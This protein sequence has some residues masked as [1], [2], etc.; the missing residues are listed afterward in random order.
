MS[1]VKCQVSGVTCHFFLD[2]VVGI[3]GGGSVF[4]GAYPVQSLH[5]THWDLYFTIKI[6]R[7]NFF[8]SPL[9]PFS[10]KNY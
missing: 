9:N 10:P 3:V 8:P 1:H 4:G 2:K 6:K 5:D 7:L